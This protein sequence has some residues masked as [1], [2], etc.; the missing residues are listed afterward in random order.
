MIF[1]CSPFA[2]DTVRNIQKAQLY[3]RKAVDEG[4]I[5][6]APHLFFPQ[7][8]KDDDPKERELGL[9]MGLALLDLS[10]EMWVFGNPSPGM[11]VEIAYATE[12]HIPIKYFPAEPA[13]GEERKEY[14]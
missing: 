10:D 1:I 8:L 2:G 7:F 14:D 5:P 12:H 6:I 4:Y 3:C 9:K 13:S 11:A